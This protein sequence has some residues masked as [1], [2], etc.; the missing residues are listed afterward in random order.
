MRTVGV[1]ARDPPAGVAEPPDPPVR[2]IEVVRLGVEVDDRAAVLVVERLLG[3]AAACDEEE[4]ALE[5][6]A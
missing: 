1:D 5:P 6:A 3:G 2:W 4:A